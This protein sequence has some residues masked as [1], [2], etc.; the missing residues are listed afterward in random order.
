MLNS[1]PAP[2]ITATNPQAPWFLPLLYAL[3]GGVEDVNNVLEIAKTSGGG[4]EHF[5]NELSGFADES[6]I[7]FGKPDGKR[8]IL[9]LESAGQREWMGRKDAIFTVA[10][11][12][13]GSY[14]SA[15]GFYLTASLEE[16]E[17]V[18]LAFVSSLYG[19]IKPQ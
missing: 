2:T 5:G 8:I 18:R 4:V 6:V 14:V 1:L 9:V 11:H 16:F 7:T 19:A 13:G 12:Y 10:V 17:A 3:L 15:T